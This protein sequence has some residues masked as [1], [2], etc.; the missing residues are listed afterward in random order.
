MYGIRKIFEKQGASATQKIYEAI[1]MG[2]EQIVTLSEEFGIEC[3]LE[4]SG[5]LSLAIEERQVKELQSHKKFYDAVGIE[6]DLIEKETLQRMIKSERYI[7][8]LHDPRG[9]NIDP[10]K[11]ARGMKELIENMGVEVYERSKILRIIPGKNVIVE[12]ELGEVSASVVVNA[13]NGY[14][15]QIGIFKNRVIPLVNYVIATEPLSEGQLD[16]IGWEGRQALHDLRPKFDYFRLTAD[17]RIVIGGEEMPYFYNDSPSTGNSKPIV[18]NLVA[19]LS[20]TFPQLEGVR[21]THA[22]GGTMGFTLDYLPSVGVMGDHKNIYY[23]TGFSGGG[24]VMTQLSGMIISDLYAGVQSDLTQ[25][26]IV[27]HRMPFAGFEPFRYP[28]SR[29]VLRVLDMG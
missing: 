24:V 14:A 8:G 18:N 5:N 3:D 22:W 27:N 7:A 29:L 12:T 6:A 25:L 19:S 2:L 16:S 1:S 11:L 21:V 28:I 10:A 9:G 26:P 15:P 23:A 13:L 17:N 4:L 20:S